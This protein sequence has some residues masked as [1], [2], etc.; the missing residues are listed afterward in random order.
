VNLRSVQRF[1][2]RHG[3]RS[4]KSRGKSNITERLS[5]VEQRDSYLRNLVQ[6]RELPVE[7]QLQEVYVDECYVHHYHCTSLFSALESEGQSTYEKHPPISARAG[8]GRQYCVLAAGTAFGWVP[9][10]TVVF[11]THS[12]HG[13]YHGN[14]TSELFLK[15]F[16]ERLL[17]NLQRPSL[18]IMNKSA[19]HRSF[20]NDTPIP[21]KMKKDEAMRYLEENQIHFDRQLSRASLLR[22]VQLHI[23]HTVRPVVV[24]T[25]EQKGHQ[26]LWIPSLHSDLNPCELAWIRA[27]N[28]VAS[29]FN[30]ETTF[31][32]VRERLELGLSLCND[33]FWTQAIEH[34]Y[35]EGQAVL[36]RDQTL[37]DTDKDDIFDPIVDQHDNSSS[38][39]REEQMEEEE[40]EEEEEVIVD[41]G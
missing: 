36:Y 41:L 5:I 30:N 2:R 28:H 33:E 29:L 13:N 17:P 11:S 34:C 31:E 39:D 38:D 19:H 22:R 32:M 12:T 7:K 8:K 3:F 35:K 18:I 25:A 24:Q 40:E 23:K 27:K 21:W 4:C 15:W 6:N 20:P 9:N 10:S 37:Y 1:L 14:P 16:T 26:V